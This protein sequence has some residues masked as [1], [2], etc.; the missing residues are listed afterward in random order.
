MNNW[1]DTDKRSTGQ[2]DASAQPGRASVTNAASGA[3]PA[4]DNRQPSDHVASI[5]RA[6]I[7]C[8]P[9][10]FFAIG[11]D[12]RYM[13]Q[14]SVLREHYGDAIGKRP[15][16]YAP[17]ETTRQLWHDNNRRALAGER[18]EGEVETRVGGQTRTYYNVI[19]P[20][21]DH[22]QVY[23]ILGVNVDLTDRKQAEEAL[24]LVEVKFRQIHD[25]LIDGVVSVG[26]DGLIRDFNEA[27]HKMLGYEPEELR[28]LR[29]SDVTPPRWHAYE[30][31]IVRT[32]TLPRGH[33]E[34][35]EKEYRRKDGTIFPVELRTFVIQGKD[36]RP[37]AMWA[38][39]RDISERKRV[40]EALRRSHEEL[41]QR[42]AEGQLN[43]A[44]LEALL[45]LGR[46]TDAPLKEITDF[47]LE[48][49]V[50]LTKSKIGYLAFM[51]DDETVLSMHSWSKEAMAEC[52]IVDKPRV[53]PMATTGLWGEA[54]RQRKPLI[55]ND[56]PAPNPWKKGL[57][58]GHIAIS[59]HMNVPILDEGRV[60]VVAGVGNKDT[61]YDDPDVRQLTLLM[62]GMWALIQLR[63]V[64]RELRRHRDHLEQLVRERTEA[65]Q[66]S[67]DQ[68]QAI[69][70]GIAEG[71]LIADIVTKRFVRVNAAMC[72]ML[73]YT[74][75]ELL[76]ASLSDLH[77]PQ[78][79][80]NDTPQ[81]EAVAEGRISLNEDRP[82]LRK[83]GTILYADI[84]A[85]RI[86]YEGG[87]CVLA[88]FRDISER[89]RAQ[90]ALHKQYRTLRHLLQSSDHERQ[91]IAYE[92]HDGLAQ[93]LAGA[94][95]QLQTFDHLKQKKPAPAAKAY[96]AGV[97]MLR[98]AHF[99]T[100]RL[101][102]GVRPPIL[103]EEGIAAAITHLLNEHG[104]HGGPDIEY[105]S[106]VNFHRLV[107][108][109]ENAVYRIVQ[110]GLANACQHS[111][112]PKVRVSLAQRDD[113][114]RIEVR[115]WGV[116]FDAAAVHG[117][118]FG[119]E[120]IRQRAKLLG[121]RCSIRSA[122]GKGTRIDVELPVV[123][124]E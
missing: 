57:P 3:D 6:A 43:E 61:D 94:I 115:D 14:N 26:L 113:R 64:Q 20:I 25:S 103:D 54:A 116:G 107:P 108:I 109:L 8:L 80:A 105:R 38:I 101:I 79:V 68:L 73:G 13:L 106:K 87:P 24:R 86:V 114:L 119:L 112:S 56:Y 2:Q 118:R 52:A 70:D 75:D 123:P 91:L 16:D 44:R 62:E 63:Q 89:K 121:G 23:G 92:I 78:E 10:E 18:V 46:M 34:I 11:P 77:P 90:E 9:F 28:T 76:G 98:Q 1:K 45:Q 120:G 100:R 82:L 7:E 84:V 72:R 22:G 32:Q 59:R 41:Q 40:E 85:H 17:D 93:Q 50:A 51:N 122:P 96:E 104:L 55:T 102:S 111:R 29:Y 97:T 67:H 33:S 27:Y 42:V 30:A 31:E 74:A 48:Q 47:A 83:D 4:A 58:A 60:V 124:R 37:C 53:Y 71:L 35:Y 69:Y 88:L 81:F 110:E 36:G 49:A 66:Q 39:V 117:D 95:M 12:G 19:T 21:Q 15:E 65:L 5:L 99:E